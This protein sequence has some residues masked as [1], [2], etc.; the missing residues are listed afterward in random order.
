MSTLWKIVPV[1]CLFALCVGCGSSPDIRVSPAF[2]KLYD[3]PRT[4]A[5][6]KFKTSKFDRQKT[7]SVFWGIVKAPNA[8]EAFPSL[9]T[10]YANGRM[11]MKTVPRSEM[12]ELFDKKNL[13]EDDIIKRRDLKTVRDL[14]SADAIIIG[15][16]ESWYQR[17]ILFFPTGCIDLSMQCIDSSTGNLLWEADYNFR[18]SGTDDRTTAEGALKSLMD[19]IE[20]KV[21]E[22]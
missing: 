8:S 13:K 19:E 10:H 20:K 7:G 18:M 5:V 2:K 3:K 11:G 12:R 6:M 17:Y 22:E 9:V 16:V 4:V 1:S 14:F 21:K 15:Q